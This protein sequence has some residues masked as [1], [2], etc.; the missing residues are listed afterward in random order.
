MTDKDTYTRFNFENRRI[1]QLVSK[2]FSF[3]YP[4]FLVYVFQVTKE[5]TNSLTYLDPI[6]LSIFTFIQT[7]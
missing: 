4:F 7:S 5:I 1:C 2:H 6:I 3:C